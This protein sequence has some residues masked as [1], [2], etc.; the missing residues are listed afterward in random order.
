MYDVITV[1]GR[2]M[3]G[4]WR[5]QHLEADVVTWDGNLDPLTSQK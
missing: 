3:D 5:Q 2:N 1:V 4:A